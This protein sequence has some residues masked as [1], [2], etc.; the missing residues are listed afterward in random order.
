M[1]S[2]D[3]A[4]TSPVELMVAERVANTLVASEFTTDVA[5]EASPE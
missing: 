1:E 5:S 4:L 3:D 2:A